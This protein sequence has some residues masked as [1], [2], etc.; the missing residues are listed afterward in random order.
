MGHITNVWS[1]VKVLLFS[2]WTVILYKIK[3]MVYDW[4]R[5]KLCFNKQQKTAF[6][7]VYKHFHTSFQKVKIQTFKYEKAAMELP[8]RGRM[9]P[10]N[11]I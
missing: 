3:Y 11:K 10:L 9:Q 4:R 1:G 5:L 6:N 7:H 8:F 2:K